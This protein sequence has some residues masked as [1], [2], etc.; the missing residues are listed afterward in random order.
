MLIVLQTTHNFEST[1]T[2]NKSCGRFPAEKDIVRDNEIWQ[3]MKT[4]NGSVKL[5]NAYFDTRMNKTVVRVN[6]NTIELNI[7]RDLI[8]CQLWFKGKSEPYVVQALN[9][10][11]LWISG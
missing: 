10:T 5:F 8:Y 4:P 11:M 9:H 1:T 2:A 6:V 3:E 7:T